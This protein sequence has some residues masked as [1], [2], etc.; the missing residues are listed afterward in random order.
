VHERDLNCGER[1]QLPPNERLAAS[2]TR[3]N[4]SHECYRANPAETPD[5]QCSFGTVSEPANHFQPSNCSPIQRFLLQRIS[6]PLVKP[7][8]KHS[9]FKALSDR[10][11]ARSAETAQSTLRCIN[12][13]AS[14]LAAD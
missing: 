4:G 12:G 13:L 2:F 8:G 11:Y 5:Q 10:K 9:I 1:T 3:E 6:K 7:L 14:I